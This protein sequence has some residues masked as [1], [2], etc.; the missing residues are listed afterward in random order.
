VEVRCA[1]TALK[2]RWIIQFCA[3]GATLDGRSRRQPGA[4]SEERGFPVKKR[5][6]PTRWRKPTG[7]RAP[8]QRA[9]R[10]SEPPTPRMRAQGSLQRPSQRAVTVG[11]TN[12]NGGLALR[13][14]RS[15]PGRG[16]SRHG[17]V[18]RDTRTRSCR[19]NCDRMPH[20]VSPS[21]SIATSASWLTSMPARLT[22]RSASCTNGTLAPHGRGARGAAT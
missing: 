21:S 10:R 2:M 22:T 11:S 13:C 6:I 19:R 12:R 1:G 4:G 15:G 8:R 17:S 3:S 14:C 16:F 5:E 9:R 18:W 20:P 7:V